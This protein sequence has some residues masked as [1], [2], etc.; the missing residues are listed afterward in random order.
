M[1]S[2]FGSYEGCH[3]G[4][5]TMVGK[6]D[7]FNGCSPDRWKQ[8][9]TDGMGSDVNE[10]DIGCFF[11]YTVGLI[12]LGRECEI[13]GEKGCDIHGRMVIFRGICGDIMVSFV[14]SQDEYIFFYEVK[15]LFCGAVLTDSS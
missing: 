11:L 7:I 10:W 4:G 8:T 2:D 5:D 13:H 6:K 9:E 1:F 3:G 12:F 14:L 15:K